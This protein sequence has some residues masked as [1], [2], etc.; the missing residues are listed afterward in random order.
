MFL[1]G[2]VCE[3]EVNECVSFPCLN[4]GVCV[5]EVNKFTC[6]CAAGFTGWN[7]LQ[8]VPFFLGY[9]HSQTR[10]LSSRYR[11]CVTSFRRLPAAGSR[12]ELEI[13]ECLSNPCVNG[14]ACEDQTGGYVCN[15]PVGFSGDHCEVD[16]DECYSAP[17]LN[18]GHCQDGI[19]SFR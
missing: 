16:V 11:W 18:G 7:L 6:S 13:N 3:A 5:D 15:C 4:Q 17:C 2:A 9:F 1:S 8:N 12:C 14:G 19:D 10:I